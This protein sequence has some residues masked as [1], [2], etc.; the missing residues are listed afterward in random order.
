MSHG[1]G[2]ESGGHHAVVDEPDDAAPL[3]ATDS[4]IRRV[5]TSPGVLLFAG[6]AVIALV[7]ERSLTGSVFSGSGTLGGGVLV[8]AWGSA[9]D[10]W[11][12]YLAGYHDAGVGTTASAPPYIGAVAALAT[13]LGGKPW[14]AVDVLLFGCVP[15]AGVTAFLAARRVTSVLAARGWVAGPDARLDRKSV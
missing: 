4:V 12:E 9:G 15:A 8:P 11:R 2:Y 6:L 13:V 7:A 10:L 5:L 1:S 3:A 14:L